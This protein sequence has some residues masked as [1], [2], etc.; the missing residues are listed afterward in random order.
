MYFNGSEGA[1]RT[2]SGPFGKFSLVVNSHT[3]PSRRHWLWFPLW[4]R[5]SKVTV[6]R[7]VRTKVTHVEDFPNSA[8]GCGCPFPANLNG[9]G[10]MNSLCWKRQPS[11]MKHYP[12]KSPSSTKHPIL[13]GRK[14]PLPP[15]VHF[16]TGMLGT[17]QGRD[18]EKVQSCLVCKASDKEVES[19]TLLDWAW[20]SYK[21]AQHRNVCRLAK[22]RLNEYINFS[23]VSAYQRTV[24]KAMFSSPS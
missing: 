23:K 12:E 6:H 2:P 20:I 10:A 24:M 15:S 19:N 3:A 11:E 14:C 7:G 21:R 13:Q 17:L 22:M 1:R 16:P 5:K 8:K 18:P 4:C 9:R